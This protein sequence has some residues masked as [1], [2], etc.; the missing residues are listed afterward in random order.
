MMLP[1]ENVEALDHAAFDKI[2]EIIMK[3]IQERLF[4]C[5]K[6]EILMMQVLWMKKVR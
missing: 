1:P 5:V 3:S 6:Q 4:F 2:Q